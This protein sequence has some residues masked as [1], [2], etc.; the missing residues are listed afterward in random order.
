MLCFWTLWTV[1]KGRGVGGLGQTLGLGR[2]QLLEAIGVGQ[3]TEERVQGDK[4]AWVPPLRIPGDSD[5][6]TQAQEE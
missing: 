5:I 2:P 6:Y 3:I 4:G 1:I